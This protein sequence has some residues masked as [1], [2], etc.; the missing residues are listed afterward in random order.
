MALLTQRNFLPLFIT[1][2]L[3]V[4]NDNVFKSA[5]TMLVTYKLAAGSGA[6]AA[7]LV[8]LGGGIFMLPYVLFSGVAGQVADKFEKSRLIIYVKAFELLIMGIGLFVLNDG[9][10]LGLFILLF[11]MAPTP[12]SSARSNTASCR[13][14]CPPANWSRPMACSRAPPSSSSSSAPCTAG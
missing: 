6:N 10:L 9:H 2:V 14:P 1:Q 5:L 13:R 7:I 8:S 3:G 4:F 11:L 12:P